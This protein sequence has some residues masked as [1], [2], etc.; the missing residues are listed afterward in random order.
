MNPAFKLPQVLST[1]LCV[2]SLASVTSSNA[3]PLGRVFYTPE[4]R[5]HLEYSKLQ[6]GN[7]IDSSR[8]LIVNGIVQ[9][10]GGKRTAWI[11]GVPQNA[12][13]SDESAP[14]SLPVAVPGL[15]NPVKVKVGQKVHINPASDFAQ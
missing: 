13:N 2:L 6:N 8:A 9:R 12:G 11:N 5:A 1:A 3:E 15:S 7:P 14:E 4:Q 10:H